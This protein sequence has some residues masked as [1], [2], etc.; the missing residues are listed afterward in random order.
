MKK[1]AL[2][3]T[4]LSLATSAAFIS[5]SASAEV[6]AN[7]GA[8]SDYLWRGVSQSNGAA[9][10][11]GID[12]TDARGLYAGAWVSNVDFALEDATTYEMDLYFGFAG[13][14]ADSGFGY[15]VGFI[16]YAYPDSTAEDSKN[17]LD[18]SEVFGSISYANYSVTAYYGVSADEGSDLIEESLYISADAEFEISKD[19][20]LALHIGDYQYDDMYS[21][22]DYSDFGVSVSKN[23]FTFGAS[24]TSEGDDS[25]KF[26]VSYSVDIEL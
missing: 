19:V 3:L 10:S 7:V 12:W 8:T 4:L 14:I 1:L 24:K 26:Y 23:G 2:P 13:D 21:D 16:Y 11:G 5:T 17:D 15:D 9:V 22:G 20:T 18:F 6:T 25:T